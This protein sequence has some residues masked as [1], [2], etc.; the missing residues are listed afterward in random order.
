MAAIALLTVVFVHSKTDFLRK[1]LCKEE[2]SR[3]LF[4]FK[5]CN[6]INKTGEVKVS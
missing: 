3:V 2:L 6:K 5:S 1:L 4:F